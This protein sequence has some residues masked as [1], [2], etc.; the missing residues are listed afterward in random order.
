[1]QSIEYEYYILLQRKRLT[2]RSLFNSYYMY[3]YMTINIHNIRIDK[4]TFFI[5]ILVQETNFLTCLCT[6]MFKNWSCY[7]MF[8][9]REGWIACYVLSGFGVLWMDIEKDNQIVL[10]RRPTYHR[11][12][13]TQ[14]IW[15]LCWEKIAVKATR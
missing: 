15:N 5:I 13:S 9:A 8:E 14:E 11:F 4:D 3:I 1:M 12:S 7:Y 10:W 6:N 2:L